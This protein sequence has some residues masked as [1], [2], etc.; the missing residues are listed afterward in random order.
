MTS[1]ESEIQRAYY[2]RTADRYDDW[3]VADDDE[4]FR[5]LGLMMPFLDLV[6]ARTLLDVG[7]G[8]GRALRYFAE[9]RPALETRGL[10]PVPALA[11]KAVEAGVQPGTIDIGDGLTMPYADDA[12][13]AVCELG[14][15]HHIADPNAVVRE[16]TRVASRAILLSDNNCFGWGRWPLRLAKNVLGVTGL[17][18]P[19]LRVKNGGRSYMLSEDD[20][21]AYTYSVLSALPV[22]RPWADEVHVIPTL[23]GRETWQAPRLTASHLLVV[24]LRH[25]R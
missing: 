7:T 4:H 19:A 13:D 12:F 20:G 21:L 2:A 18:Q 3:H 8:T 11:E 17:L 10:E 5:A 22:L 16:M 1:S 15:L 25:G 23:P 9:H 6:G 24:A 14:V